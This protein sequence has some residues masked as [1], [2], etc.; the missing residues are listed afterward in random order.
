MAPD[1]DM[2]VLTG[3]PGRKCPAEAVETRAT[4]EAG[5]DIVPDNIFEETGEGSLC[6]IMSMESYGTKSSRTTSAWKPVLL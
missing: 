1:H 4:V 5:H 2:H 3:K 6:E